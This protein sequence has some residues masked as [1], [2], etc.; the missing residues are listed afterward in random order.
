[1]QMDHAMDPNIIVMITMLSLPNGDS[2]VH[3]KPFETVAACTKAAEIEQTDPFVAHVQC[4]A[5]TDGSLTLNFKRGPT[6]PA[7][8]RRGKVAS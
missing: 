7:S 2:G 1:M 5:L 3:I 8:Q 6:E 4:S